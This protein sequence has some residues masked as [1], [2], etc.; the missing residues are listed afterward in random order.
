MSAPFEKKDGRSLNISR[1][2]G[3]A[4]SREALYIVNT[5]FVKLSNQ[6]IFLMFHVCSSISLEWNIWKIHTINYCSTSTF[7]Y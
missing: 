5:I 1:Q 4:N 3:V 2:K 7:K 6:R